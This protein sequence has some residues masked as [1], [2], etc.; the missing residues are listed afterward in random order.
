MRENRGTGEGPH[1]V[2][3]CWRSSLRRIMPPDDTVNLSVGRSRA[4]SMRRS[5]IPKLHDIRRE[6]GTRTVSRRYRR[7]RALPIW[8]RNSGSDH[9]VRSLRAR[10]HARCLLLHPRRTRVRLW[11]IFDSV[12]RVTTGSTYPATLWVPSCHSTRSH[13][14]FW[15]HPARRQ[16]EIASARSA[17]YTLSS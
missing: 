5:I 2:S 12:L 11:K 15:L 4:A 3:Y 1:R 17:Y 10:V 6:K 9:F 8:M 16:V 13:A 7:D 14:R